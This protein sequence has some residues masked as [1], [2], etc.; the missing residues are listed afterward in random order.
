MSISNQD[1]L[2]KI[3]TDYHNIFADGSAI[4]EIQ[5]LIQSL[6]RGA[7]ILG[8]LENARGSFSTIFVPFHAGTITA[9][10]TQLRQLDL[11]TSCLEF[12]ERCAR[13]ESLTDEM[14]SKEIEPGED[15]RKQLLLALRDFLEHFPSEEEVMLWK[16]K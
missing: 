15:T 8:V 7:P 10:G 4:Q 11:P 12:M 16:K 2:G 3:S 14:P 1:I 5:E 9:D 13:I 6:E